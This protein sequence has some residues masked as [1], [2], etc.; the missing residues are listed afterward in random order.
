[1]VGPRQGLLCRI[2]PAPRQPHG[3]IQVRLVRSSRQG[4]T[5][6]WGQLRKRVWLRSDGTLP[7]RNTPGAL[8]SKERPL[9]RGASWVRA[10]RSLE[11]RADP[12]ADADCG[13]AG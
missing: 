11:L 9:G 1:M 3:N 10:A 6:G 4:K 5:E 12:I 8:R 13:P 7:S 2:Y